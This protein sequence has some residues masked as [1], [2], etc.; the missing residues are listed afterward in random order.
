MTTRP[1]KMEA[2]ELGT[3]HVAA[4]RSVDIY[5]SMEQYIAAMNGRCMLIDHSIGDNR[6]IHELTQFFL[7][8]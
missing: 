6:D 2:D 7:A 3:V 5:S 8:V 4:D 1:R